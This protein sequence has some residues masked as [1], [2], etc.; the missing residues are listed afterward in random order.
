MIR[1]GILLGDGSNTESIK[2]I[3]QFND[4]KVTGIVLDTDKQDTKNQE[5]TIEDL[6]SK[7]DAT[8]IN[9][10]NPSFE[11]IQMGIKQSN[12]L[13]LKQVPKLT[14]SE[15]K[16]LI[17]LVNEAGSI[18][19]LFNPYVF[20]TENLKIQGHLKNPKFINIRL[21]LLT[22][23]T[24]SQLLDL[25]LFL[26]VTE[27]NEVKRIDVFAFEGEKKSSLLNIR[28]VFSTGSIA[29][30]HLGE[31]FKSDQSLLEIFQMD[32]KYI[33]LPSQPNNKEI[34]QTEQNAFNQFTKAIQHK[35]CISVSFNE[36][37]Q[38]IYILDEIREK[39]K[40]SE[41]SLLA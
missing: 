29:Q 26:S 33:S 19:Q 2:L 16:Q 8:Y 15:T 1:I 22:Q 34:L 36:L 21:P 32:E 25:L 27:K 40:Y 4:F 24:E 11:L 23:N 30:I 41:C 3:R 14:L 5:Y 12:H 35:P 28:I 6:V 18:V 38:T 17:S 9:T 10:C 31:M 37:E 20:L 13:F 7:S 39:L